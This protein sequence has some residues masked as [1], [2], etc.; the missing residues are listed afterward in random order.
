M[1]SYIFLLAILASTAFAQQ[2]E[3]G[4]AKR[5]VTIDTTT[6]CYQVFVPQAYT[7]E[8]KWPVILFLHGFGEGGTDCSA[9]TEVGLGPA[10]LRQAEEFPAIVVFPQTP[11]RSLWI[12]EKE[13]MA[14]KALEQTIDEFSTDP[15]RVYLT[16]LSLGG[17]GT[18]Y[19]AVHYPNKFA[20]IAPVCGGILPPQRRRAFPPEIMAIVPKEKPYETIAKQ[21][22]KTPVWIFHGS[23]DPRVPV[24][25]SR[26]MYQALQAAGG[27][28][29]YTE[30]PGVLHNSWDNAYAEPGFFEWL[31][32]QKLQVISAQ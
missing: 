7:A 5:E 10:I 14:M 21:V 18:W 12:G 27:I 19:L 1:K 2:T 31:F 16:G 3:T 20:A 13:A 26:Q 4:F 22:G 6:Y 17:Y 28:V 24:E 30:Y 11:R 15:A 25:E 29:K 23:D 9:Q 8:K 32:S